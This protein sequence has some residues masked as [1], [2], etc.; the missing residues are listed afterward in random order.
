MSLQHELGAAEKDCHVA[1]AEEAAAEAE[2]EALLDELAPVGE[3]LQGDGLWAGD[4]LAG[5]GDV[6]VQES[7]PRRL[8]VGN[9]KGWVNLKEI[10]R[11]REEISGVYAALV[12]ERERKAWSVRNM[13]R[14]VSA[15]LPLGWI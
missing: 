5:M 4:D 8:V 2:V 13:E 3:E 11:K 6:E 9:V 12:Q 1:L 7:G 15:F 14:D 10:K